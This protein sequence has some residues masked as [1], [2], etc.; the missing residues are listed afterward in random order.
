MGR[1]KWAELFAVLGGGGAG[2]GAGSGGEI[3]KKVYEGEESTKRSEEKLE[4]DIL[5][6]LFFLATA[7]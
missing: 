3:R 4:E 7:A 5:L 2:A 1:K 6:S